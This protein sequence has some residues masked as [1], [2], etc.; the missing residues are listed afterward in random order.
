MLELR[1]ERYGE[2]VLGHLAEGEHAA[3]TGF[4]L[5]WARRLL[6]SGAQASTELESQAGNGSVCAGLG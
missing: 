2:I 6:K 5:D 1:R 4:A 3:V